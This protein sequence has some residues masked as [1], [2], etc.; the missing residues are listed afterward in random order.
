[1]GPCTQLSQRLTLREVF[2]RSI[3]IVCTPAFP[4]GGWGKVADSGHAFNVSPAS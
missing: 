4:Q 2:P 3:E 1:M